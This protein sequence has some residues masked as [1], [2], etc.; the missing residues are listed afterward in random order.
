MKI[1]STHLLPGLAALALVACSADPADRFARAQDAFENHRYDEARL[2]L[3]SGLK[4]RPGDV[5][6]LDMLARTQLALGDGEGAH[7]SLERLEAAGGLPGDAPLLF[8]EAALLRRQFDEAIARVAPEKSAEA[9][10]IR[11]VARVGKGELAEAGKAFGEG[12]ARDDATSRLLA[13]YAIFALGNGALARARE[14]VDRALELEPDGLDAQLAQGRVAIAEGDLGVALT[15]YDTALKRYPD[16]PTALI[17]K[18]GVLGDLGSFDEAEALIGDAA[19]RMSNSAD[20]V[21]LRARLAGARGDWAKARDIIQSNERALADRDDAQILYGEALVELERYELAR[22]TLQP[23]LRRQPRNAY[24]RRLM[25]RSQLGSGDAASALATIGPLA[26]R[27]EAS[28]ADLELAARAA[29]ETGSTK[30]KAYRERAR[31]PSPA[32]LAAEVATADAAM[33]AGNWREAISAYERIIA[34]T[35]EENVLVLNNFAFALGQ[36]GNPKRGLQYARRALAM[37]PE[38]PSVLDT[39]GWLLIETGGDRAEA[40][41]LLEKAA[42]LAPR[43]RTIADHLRQAKA[44]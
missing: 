44:R 11:A 43:N 29:Q 25:A 31:V 41:R 24:A 32:N 18:A 38:N 13:D 20:I 15:A 33:K 37:A 21:Y 16:N 12:A 10:R 23:V 19:G 14:L 5:A 28:Q 17:G 22:A 8:G 3:V 6:M 34:A 39:V 9:W 36:S 2:D 40:V 35:G 1:H 7:A 4:E 27:A 26:D 30:A 42:K